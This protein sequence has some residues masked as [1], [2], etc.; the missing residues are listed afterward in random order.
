VAQTGGDW[1]NR[2]LLSFAELCFAELCFALLSFA[3]LI[4]AEHR[5]AN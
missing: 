1:G 3:L 2:P 4:F 5:K